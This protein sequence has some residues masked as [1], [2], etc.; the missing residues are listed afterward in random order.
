MEGTSGCRSHQSKFCDRGMR[1]AHPKDSKNKRD[2]YKLRPNPLK[3][4]S[5]LRKFQMETSGTKSDC[6][7]TVVVV[8]LFFVYTRNASQPRSSSSCRSNI[9]PSQFIRGLRHDNLPIALPCI[10][11]RSLDVNGRWRFFLDWS[12]P[13]A[14]R[15][16]LPSN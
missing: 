15:G 8:V 2:L 13:S 4:Q 1:M 6:F 16:A 3:F 10:K 9:L 5:S 11:R 12:R 14:W 7:G